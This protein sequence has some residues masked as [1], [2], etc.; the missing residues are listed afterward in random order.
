MKRLLVIALAGCTAAPAWGPGVQVDPGPDTAWAA[1]VQIAAGAWGCLTVAE[2]GYPVLLEADPAWPRDIMGMFDGDSVRVRP[3]LAA[4]EL[5]V[6][7]HELGHALGLEHSRDPS[8]VMIAA[9]SLNWQPS[10]RDLEVC[11]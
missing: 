9:V 11:R 8:S 5:P 6:L 2:G 3:G 10:A 1:Q 7:V 4:W